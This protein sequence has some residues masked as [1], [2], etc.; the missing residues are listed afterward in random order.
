[1]TFIGLVIFTVYTTAT[2]KS[3]LCLH[4]ASV[5]VTC[6][7]GSEAAESS[8][9][10]PRYLGEFASAAASYAAA[11]KARYRP[12]PD[13]RVDGLTEMMCFPKIIYRITS[14]PPPLE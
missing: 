13:E 11:R 14:Q 5:T 8:R 3:P 9:Q 7:V 4:L 6:S 12:Q 1:M 10:E 2:E